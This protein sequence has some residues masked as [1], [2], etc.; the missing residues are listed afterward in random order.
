MGGRVGGAFELA[1]VGLLHPVDHDDGQVVRGGDRRGRLLR[2]GGAGGVDGGDGLGGQPSGQVLGLRATDV[3]ERHARRPRVEGSDDVAFGAAV[4]GEDEPHAVV[5]ARRRS[6]QL[7]AAANPSASDGPI[8]GVPGAPD[9][10]PLAA[11]G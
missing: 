2:A 10:R 8:T 11:R 7:C 4:P 3:V 6:S 9:A 5:P 1:A